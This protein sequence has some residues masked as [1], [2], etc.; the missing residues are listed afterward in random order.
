MNFR[1][2]PYGRTQNV[3]NIQPVIPFH[4]NEH[5]NL[6]TRTILPVMS[7]PNPFR[8]GGRADGIGDLNPTFFFSPGQ[9]GVT[10]F[11][12]GPSFFLP[13]ANE[14]LLGTGHWS[15]G[16]GLVVVSMPGPWVLGALFNN[17]WSV[18]GEKGR[19]RVN[20]MTFQP[21]VNYNLEK[22][23]YLISSPIITA[24]WVLPRRD[25]WIIPC[26]G[27]MGRLFDVGALHVNAETQAFYDVATPTVNGPRWGIRL[28]VKFL[29]PEN[30][31]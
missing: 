18:A 7:Q 31:A 4:L 13:T 21:F 15:V 22:G 28:E 11:G 30:E 19:P 6:I 24:N 9:K 5:W 3:L 16:P 20:Q 27:G 14:S 23:W 1:L 8:A 25:Q 26:G 17:V 2:T 29:F 10:A 12:V